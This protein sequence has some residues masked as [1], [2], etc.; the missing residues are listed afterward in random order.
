M[1]GIAQTEKEDLKMRLIDADKLIKS[2][3]TNLG[4]PIWQIDNAPTVDAIKHGYWEK[5]CICSVCGEK[6]LKN[7][8]FRG[9]TVW[10]DE[11]D[12]C[13]HCGAKMSKVKT[14]KLNKIIDSAKIKED[15]NHKYDLDFIILE[16][17]SR[18]YPPTY[19]NTNGKWS[20]Y[21][22]FYTYNEEILKTELFGDSQEEVVSMAKQWYK[23][24]FSK[25]VAIL[26][27]EGKED[28]AD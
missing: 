11:Y 26:Q 3:P 13:P 7:V 19:Y 21:V 14:N 27:D 1:N 15:C 12:Y 20:M 18:G 4:V 9:E 24:N 23:D 16:A 5:G 25:A 22:G 28:E 10:E 8:I 2:A 17:S 6:V